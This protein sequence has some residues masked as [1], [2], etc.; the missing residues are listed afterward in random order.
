MQI[1]GF[2]IKRKEEVQPLQSVVPPSPIET[3][4]TVVNTGVNAGGYYGMV[5]DLEGVI[6]NENDLIRRYREVSQYSDCDAAIEDIVNEAIVADEDRN[7]VE[8]VLD[9]VNLSENIKNK[10]R[11]EFNNI[12]KILKFNERAHETFRAWYIDGRLYYQIL[13]DENNVKGG[14][15]ELRYIDPRK[16]RRIKN[17]KKERT[18]G[19]VE[20]VKEVEEYYLYN[21]KGITEQ[22]TQGVKLGLD[23]VVY[24]P[25][26]FMDPN[27]GM[28]MSYLHKA[29]KPVNQLK[30]IEDS[31][32]IYRISRA[33]ERRIFYVDVGNLPKLKAEQYV[34]DIMNKF[35]NKIVYDATTG[36]TRDD[37]RHLSMMEDFWMPRREGGKGTEITTLPGGQ[38]L[39]EI[40]DIEYFQNKLYMSL[41]VPISRLQQSQGFSI[42]R[43]QEIN[44][45]EIKFNKFIVRLRKKFSILFSNALRVQLIAKGVITP[46]DWDEISYNIKYDYLED[47]HYAELRDAEIMQSR[48]NLLQV[49]DPFI[50]K[51]YSMDWAKR[52]ILRM[53]K[54]EIKEM[55]KQIA[56][57]QKQMIGIANQQ[58][59]IQ[60]AMQQPMMDAQ[61]EQQ[62]QAM[63]QQQAAQEQQPAEQ[64]PAADQQD[65]QDSQP[66][67]KGKSAKQSGWPN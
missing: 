62:Q 54:D 13:I 17:I 32:V 10:I 26:G 24:C 22:T 56:K 65:Q 3:G 18:A 37:R 63:Q 50:G 34:S 6:K 67:A 19:G 15:V 21:D 64:E 44:R 51:Y 2:E 60:L 41:N 27:T 45:D 9:E 48:M 12:L 49:V 53:D 31:L 20:V 66:K 35:R 25:S 36:E 52:N 55:D 5:M 59:E 40:Q 39:G 42:G 30:M 11:E 1:F 4:A 33:P 14:I 28:A 43:S 23:S 61:Q 46:D 7:S 16:I 58:G 8:I 29:I 38:N 57:E 47:N